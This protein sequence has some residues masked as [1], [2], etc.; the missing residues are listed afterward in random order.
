MRG[1]GGIYKRGPVYW[2]RYSHRGRKYRES[3]KSPERAVA[4]ALLT[5]RLNEI[6]QGRVS[7]PAEERVTFEELA[8]DYV[9]ERALHVTEPKRLKW[10]TA[11]VNNLST[12]F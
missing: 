9:Q 2:I 12:L 8:A 1:M 4:V 11:R 5:Q 10:S 7:G 6:H 3:S